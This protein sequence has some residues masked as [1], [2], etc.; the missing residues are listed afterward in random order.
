M[1]SVSPGASSV[2][3]LTTS[4][5]LSSSVEGVWK[6][7][8]YRSMSRGHCGVVHPRRLRSISPMIILDCRLGLTNSSIFLLFWSLLRHIHKVTLPVMGIFLPSAYLR[9]G[10]CQSVS[11]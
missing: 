4:S 3:L 2:M 10:S 9:Q 8:W 1:G 11:L 7:V 6:R 5:S